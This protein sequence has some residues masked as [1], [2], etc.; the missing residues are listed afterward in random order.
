MGVDH[1]PESSHGLGGFTHDSGGLI[2]V[3]KV[4]GQAKYVFAVECLRC[5]CEA[6]GAA[7]A[8][9]DLISIREE[10]LSCSQPDPLEPPVTST[11]LVWVILLCVLR[12]ASDLGDD[13]SRVVG[14]SFAAGLWCIWDCTGKRR[15]P[16][17]TRGFPVAA[18]PYRSPVC[19]P[20]MVIIITD[21]SWA[22]IIFGSIRTSE[23]GPKSSCSSCATRLGRAPRGW[24]TCPPVC[25]RQ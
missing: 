10:A 22:S 24:W 18:W 17:R 9:G 8:D 13:E 12:L 3:S 23:N 7:S 19:V 14:E 25:S 5:G 11:D 16:A 21:T 2:R 1:D 15:R 20:E 6:I 4:G